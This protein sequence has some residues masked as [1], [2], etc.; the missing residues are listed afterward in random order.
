MKKNILITGGSGFLGINLA[1]KLKKK[2]NVFIGSRNQKRNYDASKKTNCEAIP[3]DVTNIESV[4]D[5]V[6]YCKPNIIIHAAATKF[7]DISEKFPFE[8][9]DVNI[10]GSTNIARVSI[11]RKVET[12]IGISTDKA[13][14]PIK[15]FYGFSKATMEKLFLN[16][17]TNSNTNFLCVR[18][19]NVAWSTGS[20]LP[21]WSEMLKKNNKI[22]TTGPFMRRFF[23]TIDD[24]VEL[25]S[26]A[27]SESKKFSG[28]I[29]CADMKS[30]K[31]IEI[32][33]I[34]TK[35]YG[36]T[37]KIIKARKGDR[38]DEYL[39]GNNELKYTTKIVKNKKIF[40]L[41]DFEKISKKPLRN[42]ISS[43]NAKKLNNTEILRLIELG[44][45]LI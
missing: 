18:Y 31:L 29:L 1:L 40:Y 20:V 19:G 4:R 45:N 25:V 37:Y 34:W 27:L 28:K 33:K 14:Q 38:L 24:A 32:I 39:I 10:L 15:N 12:V 35:A 43:E 23:F 6:I 8:C 41:I 26:Y 2:F 13:T 17:H 44:K 21:I 22:L 5:A 3:L 11:E 30:C 16:A 9:S 42:I 7:V 36:G